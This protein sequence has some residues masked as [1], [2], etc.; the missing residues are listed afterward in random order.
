MVKNEFTRLRSNVMGSNTSAGKVASSQL[1][2]VARAVKGSAGRTLRGGHYD[3]S[4][5]R[6]Q[7]DSSELVR[8]RARYHS[9]SIRLHEFRTTTLTSS[10]LAV[11]VRVS[12]PPAPPRAVT[13]RAVTYRPGPYRQSSITPSLPSRVN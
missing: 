8:R 7:Q 13:T 12:N 3:Q 4:Q 5:P 2:L 11:V 10:P 9:R 6:R 1:R